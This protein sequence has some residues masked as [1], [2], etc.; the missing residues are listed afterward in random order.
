MHNTLTAVTT[1]TSEIGANP[2]ESPAARATKKLRDD[3]RLGQVR[4]YTEKWL[5]EKNLDRFLGVL[6]KASERGVEML[7]TPESFLDG[8]TADAKDSTREKMFAEVAQDVQDSKLLARVAQEAKS[9]KMSMVFTFTE[10]KRDKLYNSA[11]LW[12]AEGQLVGVYHKTHIQTQ[13]HQ[14]DLGEEIPVYVSPWGPLGIMICA[15]RRWPETP[16]TLRLKGARIILNPTAGMCH[17]LNECLM[18]A[19]SWENNCYVVFT[20]PMVSLVTN[21]DGEIINKLTSGED[22]LVT[23]IDLSNVELCSH[24]DMSNVTE[25][26]PELYGIIADSSLVI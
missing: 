7:V 3:M 16:R 19:R 8:Y 6:D 18:R 22:L 26:R 1:V 10:K 2:A 17:E 4:F 14:F 9:R 23:D 11:G 13:D 5:V 25:R 15:D 20:H 24:A 12:D 21:P